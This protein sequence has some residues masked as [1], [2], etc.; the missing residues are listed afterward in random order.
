MKG[1]TVDSDTD[2]LHVKVGGRITSEDLKNEEH[3]SSDGFDVS[4]TA[5]LGG[6][7]TVGLQDFEKEKRSVVRSTIGRGVLEVG[8]ETDINRDITRAEELEVDRILSNLN[9]KMT[10]DHRLVTTEGRSQML[11]ELKNMGRN[12]AVTE[13][14]L[15]IFNPLFTGIAGYIANKDI[16][17]DAGLLSSITEKVKQDLQFDRTAPKLKNLNNL[18]DQKAIEEAVKDIVKDIGSNGGKKIDIKLYDEPSGVN[19]F[20]TPDTVNP[21]GTVSRTICINL[22]NVRTERDLM[23]AIFHESYDP[24]KHGK[25]ERLA[26]NYASHIERTWDII[27]GGEP[28]RS[29]NIISKLDTREAN[30]KAKELLKT[31]NVQFSATSA[32]IALTAAEAAELGLGVAAGPV[33]VVAVG[34]GVYAVYQGGKIVKR[35]KVDREETEAKDETKQGFFSRFSG[36]N[37][38]KGEKEKDGDRKKDGKGKEKDKEKNGQKDGEKKEDNSG[39]G[40]NP[41][42]NNGDGDPGPG[43]AVVAGA[44]AKAAGGNGDEQEMAGPGGG[45]TCGTTE[46]VVGEGEENRGTELKA[47]E[48]R[49]E[50]SHETREEFPKVDKLN[51][52]SNGLSSDGKTD[53]IREIADKIKSNDYKE[54]RKNCGRGKTYHNRQNKL[55]KEGNYREYDLNPH[56]NGAKRGLERIMIDKNTGDVYY[57][58]D[59]G[60]TFMEVK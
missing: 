13:A 35:W 45:S 9:A 23:A 34:F 46:G 3:Q 30:K 28:A 56:G 10:L 5:S 18:E 60:E 22:A 40:G 37:K 59:H 29:L 16:D 51:K 24:T 2:Q 14:N 12:I 27:M 26:E 1:S 58:P 43:E 33:V 4:T 53:K 41:D 15:L 11:K 17:E 44:V 8:E 7:T 50:D 48:D 49:F 32:T 21:D 6:K 47:N 20:S 57:T 42:P 31:G 54:N 19:G 39:S 55:P 38:D 52:P 36:R 25:N